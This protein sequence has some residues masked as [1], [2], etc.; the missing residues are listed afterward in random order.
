M[1]DSDKREWEMWMHELL[2]SQLRCTMFVV[3][4]VNL[5]G[6]VVIMLRPSWCNLVQCGLLSAMF[7]L[8]WTLNITD[9][10]WY[11]N[12]TLSCGRQGRVSSRLSCRMSA[13]S[14]ELGLVLANLSVIGRSMGYKPSVTLCNKLHPGC[15]KPKTHCRPTKT[16]Q[17]FCNTIFFQLIFC[18]HGCFILCYD[19]FILVVCQLEQ[20][21]S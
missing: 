15:L 6:C 17:I 8:A 3:R 9:F 7:H 14:S 19:F 4:R 10:D 20:S 12:T 13:V 16:V 2:Y 18:L 1:T 5:I 21:S 11:Y